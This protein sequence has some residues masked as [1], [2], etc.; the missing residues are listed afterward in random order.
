MASEESSDKKLE[1]EVIDLTNDSDAEQEC[2]P[3][4]ED[5]ILPVIKME[6]PDDKDITRLNH[7][8][9]HCQNP[10]SE[11]PHKEF[12]NSALLPSSPSRNF[13]E[14]GTPQAGPK[15]T[16][17]VF[18]E[19]SAV[20]D[21]STFDLPEFSTME[22][23]GYGDCIDH[24][25]PEEAIRLYN[26]NKS[27]FEEDDNYRDTEAHQT[28][29]HDIPIDVA[30]E[31]DNDL[32]LERE[33]TVYNRDHPHSDEHINNNLESETHGNGSCDAGTGT[34]VIENAE[35][36]DWATETNEDPSMRSDKAAAKFAHLKAKYYEQ[37]CAGTVTDLDIVGFMKAEAAEKK[38]LM[39]L[40]RS[41]RQIEDEY[42]SKESTS[43]YDFEDSLFIP[44]LPDRPE[45][46]K[47]R[48]RAP[49]KPRNRVNAQE[50]REAMAV[51]S[52]SAL[53]R[54]R[55]A[56]A[57]SSEPRPR[58]RRSAKDS[59]SKPV[60][61]RAKQPILSNLSSLGRSNIIEEAQ[62]NANKPDMP[63]FSSKN[64]Q[65]ALQQLIAS[66]PSTENGAHASDK[67]AVLD[68]TK[69]FKGRGAVKADGQGKWKLKG[70]RSSLHVHQ[71][72]GAAFLRDRENGTQRPFGGL[73]CDEMGF[74]KTI[75]MM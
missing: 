19:P 2:R 26:K 34:S 13:T 32:V 7:H 72:L 70:M 66:I 22:P 63:T 25:T 29:L 43:G 60:K 11:H 4:H 23:L 61:K 54:K 44:E 45:S 59:P 21:A 67:A 18:D 71:L 5:T 51:G 38:R 56:P 42:P 12:P 57:T 52:S 24:L 68:A 53:S 75:Q 55:R 73:V 46:P 17:D 49:A 40:E 62:A 39:D 48:T 27:A 14:P 16:D 30:L 37:E 8:S 15:P 69:K 64:K 20:P 6:P 50:T 35:A 31:E 9:V 36:I 65:Q 47:R 3:P 10:T 74:G 28:S 58:K 1:P 33:L 41:Q